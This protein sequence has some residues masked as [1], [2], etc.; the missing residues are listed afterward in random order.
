MI[1]S[2]FSVLS[3]GFNDVDIGWHC[4]GSRVCCKFLVDCHIGQGSKE[5]QCGT[6]ISKGSRTFGGGGYNA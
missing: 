4:W 1:S 6:E 2:S 3:C 5:M